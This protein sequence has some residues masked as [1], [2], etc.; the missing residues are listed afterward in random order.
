MHEN[1]QLLISAPLQELASISAEHSVAPLWHDR[2][3]RGVITWKQ[4][5]QHF[6][7]KHH[8]LCRCGT[9]SGSRLI[10]E[11]RHDERRPDLVSERNLWV[12][13]A[14]NQVMQ[15][16][17][18]LKSFDDYASHC[19]EA[20]WWTLWFITMYMECIYQWHT[21][22][23]SNSSWAWPGIAEVW[24]KL[25]ATEGEK[26]FLPFAYVHSGKVKGEINGQ[27]CTQEKWKA[28]H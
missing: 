26:H 10:K 24:H 17:D 2:K 7:L 16:D 3:R 21:V 9:F 11:R 6:V 8:A 14:Q 22:K 25:D 4:Q 5:K 20:S 15:L 12:E 13:E 28:P 19:G 23:A 27:K 18:M 1:I